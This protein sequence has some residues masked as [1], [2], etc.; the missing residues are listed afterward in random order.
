MILG[1]GRVEEQLQAESLGG[2]LG[3]A[4]TCILHRFSNLP[5]MKSIICVAVA[6]HDERI[7][8]NMTKVYGLY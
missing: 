1:K 5:G 2:S 4:R 8:T 6:K 3:K 7:L